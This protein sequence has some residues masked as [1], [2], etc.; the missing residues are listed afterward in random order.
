MTTLVTALYAEGRTDE[1]F[2]PVVLQRTMVDLLGRGSKG[3]VEVLQPILL[4]PDT[5][6]SRAEDILAVARKAAGYH[7]LFIHADADQA[8]RANALELRIQPG[9]SLVKARQTA[10]DEVC[11]DLVP[12]IPVQMVEA[13]L[14]ADPDALRGIIG[15]T[16]SPF[17]LGMPLRPQEIEGEAQPKERLA[18]IM[19]IAYALRPRRRRKIDVRDL[20]QPLAE[21]ISIERLHRLPAFQEFVTDVSRALTTLGFI[22]W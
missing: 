22:A 9:V 2:L 5:K 16:M 11:R 21:Q 13:W 19:R 10:G 20:Y 17:E 15:T 3:V 1:R 12:V 6:A 4:N 7:L 18:E 8:T 14:L